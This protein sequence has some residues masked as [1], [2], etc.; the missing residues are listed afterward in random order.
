MNLAK[1][2]LWITI[3]LAVLTL[4]YASMVLLNLSSVYDAQLE[5]ALDELYQRQVLR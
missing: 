2:F 3:A 1:V 5:N 4:I